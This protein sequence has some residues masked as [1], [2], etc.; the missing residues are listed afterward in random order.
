MN[1]KLISLVAILTILVSSCIVRSIH[2][3]YK[4]KDVVFKKELLGTWIDSDSSAWKFS[5]HMYYESFMGPKKAANSYDVVYC[6][7]ENDT[8]YFNVHLFMLK[9]DYTL[10]VGKGRMDR[11]VLAWR[12]LQTE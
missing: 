1:R 10:A 5:Q 2:P 3:F 7:E 6:E 4:D 9:G 8:S 11:C 12:C